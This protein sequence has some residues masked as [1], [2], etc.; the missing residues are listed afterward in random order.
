[1]DGMNRRALVLNAGSLLTWG[2]AAPHAL[3]APSQAGTLAPVF[4]RMRLGHVEI[5]ALSDGTH[6]LRI[7]TA[8]VRAW[9]DGTPKP[10]VQAQPGEA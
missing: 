1:M 9:L 8:M 5:T 2:A 10:L 7:P 4:C 3:A 6:I